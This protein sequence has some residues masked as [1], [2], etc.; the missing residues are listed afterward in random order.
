MLTTGRIPNHL[1]PAPAGLLVEF[2]GQG[3]G[4]SIQR[5]LFI[6]YDHPLA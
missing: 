4:M 6:T 2:G 3:A 1:V 5:N